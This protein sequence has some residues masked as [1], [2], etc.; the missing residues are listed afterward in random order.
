MKYKFLT[1]CVADG[2]AISVGTVTELSPYA[3]QV[4]L[5]NR[6]I[7]EFEEPVVQEPEV[8]QEKAKPGRR[9]GVNKSADDAEIDSLSDGEETSN[10][11]E[12]ALS[13]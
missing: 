9:K 10:P 11:L 13:Q 1:G 4:L 12:E 3:A 5:S 8:K 2:N 7:E 6:L